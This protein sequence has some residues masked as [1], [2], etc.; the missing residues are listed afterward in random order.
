MELIASTEGELIGL[1]QLLLECTGHPD[2]R[3]TE[4]LLDFWLGVQDLPISTR[5]PQLCGPIYAQLLQVLVTQCMYPADFTTW[6]EAELEYDDFTKFREQAAKEMLG[7]CMHLLRQQF[8]APLVEALRA[9]P[10][11]WQ[12]VEVRAACLAPT[13]PYR[14]HHC[15]SLCRKSSSFVRRSAPI[16][17]L[18]TLTG[19]R[20][21]C[22]LCCARCTRR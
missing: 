22:S 9:E 13:G 4:L 8:F 5:N 18:C 11:V 14:A 19:A 3:V 10:V 17:G 7:S 1:L 20:R 16:R 6:E 2:F 21:W 15:L 12:R